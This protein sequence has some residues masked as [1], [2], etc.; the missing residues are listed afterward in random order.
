MFGIETNSATQKIT[1]ISYDFKPMDKVT[2]KLTSRKK[3]SHISS[4]ITRRMFLRIGSSSFFF[5]A[6]GCN[7]SESTPNDE[8]TKTTTPIATTPTPQSTEV[9]L[10]FVAKVVKQPTNNGPGVIE[11]RL[12]NSGSKSVDIGFGPT[13]LFT[14]NSDPSLVWS[15]EL[16]LIPSTRVG[17][18]E[19]PDST[20]EGC[21]RYTNDGPYI[22]SI[23]EWRS[24]DPGSSISEQYR[25]YTRGTDTPCL[26]VGTYRYEDKEYVEEESRPIL[27]SL[28]LEVPESG[29]LSVDSE[30]PRPV[31]SENPPEETE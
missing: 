18:V 7:S 22:R 26:P 4:M 27:L 9:P 30:G 24:L 23:L 28:L 20:S 5:G 8:G 11:A 3:K 15:D 2:R 13:L 10:E 21:W 16:V 29:K 1:L 17:P 19:T 25:L 14:D 12:T 6:S 31:A